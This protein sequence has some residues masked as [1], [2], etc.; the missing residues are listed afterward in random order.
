MPENNG[1]PASPC[2]IPTVNGFSIAPEKPTCAATY[3][4]HSPV[5]ESYPIDTASGT[6]IITNA[7]VSSLIPNTAPNR[8]NITI[9]NAMTTRS[10][11]RRRI[12][13]CRSSPC[14]NRR[15]APIPASTARLLFI[16][17]NAPPIIN[18]KAMIPACFSNPSSSDVN[19]CHVCGERSAAW[20]DP[21]T[22]T[23][24]SEPFT[25]TRSRTYSPGGITHDNAAQIKIID[26]IIV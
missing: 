13:P 16:T 20:N 5:I 11:P 8:L 15:N 23:V 21:S 17:W 25:S 7:S 10:T 2:A 24:R 3:T 26:E 4:I 1:T 14:V 19:T 22:I 12:H 6:I 18:K 9:T